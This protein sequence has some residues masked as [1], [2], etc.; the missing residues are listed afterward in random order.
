MM[1]HSKVFWL[2]AALTLIA[3]MP[4]RA[5]LVADPGF[6]GCTSTS[7]QP[8]GW[9]S[10]GTAYCATYSHSGNWAEYLGTNIASEISQTI[11]TTVGNV[12]DF[13]F[14]AAYGSSSEGTDLEAFF[15]T[16]MVFSQSTFLPNYTFENFQITATTGSTTIAFVA[17]QSL[18]LV[19]NWF[20]DDVSVTD[21][22]APVPEPASL[23]LLGAGLA[24]LGLTRRRKA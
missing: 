18:D 6:E 14:W 13:S 7:G 23:V 19:P 12:Y 3:G 17:T 1:R 11:P 15:G 20:V 4:A 8:P 5:N 10:T 24:G 16:D 22:G 9:V 21:L 2:V